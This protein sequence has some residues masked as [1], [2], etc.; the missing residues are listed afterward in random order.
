[1]LVNVV[2]SDKGNWFAY[3]NA[4]SCALSTRGTDRSVRRA[5]SSTRVIVR[6]RHH[7][8]PLRFINNVALAGIKL[9]QNKKKE[10]L[11]PSDIYLK[12]LIFSWDILCAYRSRLWMIHFNLCYVQGIYCLKSDSRKQRAIRRRVS[13]IGEISCVA[14]SRTRFYLFFYALPRLWSSLR[15]VAAI[16]NDG[17]WHSHE[18][19][20]HATRSE[21]NSER[22]CSGATRAPAWHVYAT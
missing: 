7:L 4:T 18:F 22:R 5:F 16:I 13:A 11:R 10:T 14:E 21:R 2:I 6:A 8:A 19:S 1:M 20:W 17:E 3:N 12:S 15:N 9:D